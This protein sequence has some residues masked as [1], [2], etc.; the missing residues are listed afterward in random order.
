MA[1]PIS[2]FP[3]TMPEQLIERVNDLALRD[4]AGEKVPMLIARWMGEDGRQKRL[5]WLPATEFHKR[6]GAWPD[7]WEDGRPVDAAALMTAAIRTA[8]LS[9]LYRRQ[10]E[11]AR[12]LREIA[13][14]LS[15]AALDAFENSLEIELEAIEAEL[16]RRAVRT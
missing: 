9:S 15:S 2:G 8:S 3:E 4:M 13:Q 16:E 12:D 11:I 6:T 7:G 14:E 10:E 5:I 1:D